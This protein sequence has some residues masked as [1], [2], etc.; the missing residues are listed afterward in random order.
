M[1]QNPVALDSNGNLVSASEALKHQDYYCICNTCHGRMRLVE[2]PMV[3]PH[4]RHIDPN[5]NHPNETFLHEY[6]KHHIAQQISCSEQFFISYTIEEKCCKEICGFDRKNCNLQK[7]DRW[8]IKQYGYNTVVIE[9]NVKTEKGPFT[10]DV[11]IESHRFPDNPIFI[12]VEVT[13]PCTDEKLQSGYRI[14]EIKLPEDYNMMEH[15]LKIDSLKEGDMGNGIWIKFH[16]FTKN[17]Q[18]E[19]NEPLDKKEIKAIILKNDG[20]VA[21]I[22]SN[23]VCSKYGNKI[24]RDS[25]IEVHFAIDYSEQFQVTPLKAVAALYGIPCKNCRFC[26]Q[27]EYEYARF[28][29]RKIPICGRSKKIITLG[30]DAEI[31]QDYSFSERDALKWASRLKETT[32]VAVDKN[33]KTMNPLMYRRELRSGGMHTYPIDDEI[34]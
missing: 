22:Y 3:Q 16:N 21:Y 1:I 7:F 29:Y 33:G 13:N 12:E 14:I 30:N 31:C 18:R 17:R 27:L 9:K 26:G 10:P 25:E 5:V 11:L 2:G 20:K 28:N 34:E 23:L 19:S 8:D 32:Y 24:W 15:P 6:A 4:F